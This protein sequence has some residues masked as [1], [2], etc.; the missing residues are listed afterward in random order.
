MIFEKITKVRMT[1][2]NISVAIKTIRQWVSS[3]K[4]AIFAVIEGKHIDETDSLT[5]FIKLRKVT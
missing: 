2:F 1:H 4:K 3:I 5:T